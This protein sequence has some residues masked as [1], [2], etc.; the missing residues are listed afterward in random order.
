MQTLGLDLSGWGRT[1]WSKIWVLQRQYI[2]QLIMPETIRGA[3]G[4][5][6]S[7]YCQDV[8][9]GD[10]S[11]SEISSLRYGPWRR[12]YAGLHEIDTVT[13]T[14]LVPVDNSVYDYFS[15]W[16]ELV[17]DED[18]Y[19]HPKN[20]YKKTIFVSLYDRSGVQ[21]VKFTLKGVFPRMK[22]GFGLSYNSEGILTLP[23]VL[24]VDTIEASSLI[25]SIRE[26][27]VNFAGGIAGKA[28]SMLGK[29]PKLLK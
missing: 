23:M 15:G 18:G 20:K 8:R 5:L 25:G 11:M 16:S 22:P 12:F 17:V 26:G 10:Y 4:Y 28:G 27:V 29:V 14:F 21:S 2:W 9:F 7:Q 13:L 3:I 1:A 24:S 19:Y 6:V